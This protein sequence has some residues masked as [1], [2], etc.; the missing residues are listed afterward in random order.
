MAAPTTDEV[1]ARLEILWR[2]LEDEGWYVK[3][4]T[5]GLAIDEIKRLRDDA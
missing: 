2:K 1:L 4:N 5:V 3:A